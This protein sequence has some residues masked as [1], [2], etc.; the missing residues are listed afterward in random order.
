MGFPDG[1]EGKESAC[2]A[3][4]LGLIPGVE[5]PF[6]DVTSLRNKHWTYVLRFWNFPKRSI[7][8]VFF[9]VF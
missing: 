5:L 9:R 7:R 4:D 2:S 3:R 1:S 8:A 6:S